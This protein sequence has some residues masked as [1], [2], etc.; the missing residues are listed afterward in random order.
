MIHNRRKAIIFLQKALRHINKA[1]EMAEDNKNCIDIIRESET[2][3]RCLKVADEEILLEHL[4]NCMKHLDT[5]QCKSIRDILA[6][7]KLSRI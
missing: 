6:I 2:A 5:D 7:Y 1:L 4:I 3:R